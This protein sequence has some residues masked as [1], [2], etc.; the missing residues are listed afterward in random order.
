MVWINYL[1]GNSGAW[2]DA[3]ADLLKLKDSYIE[4]LIRSK[5][6]EGSERLKGRVEAIEDVLKKFTDTERK[7]RADAARAQQPGQSKPAT[8]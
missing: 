5:E 3:Q 4:L 2:K 6:P 7:E 1:R 8:A